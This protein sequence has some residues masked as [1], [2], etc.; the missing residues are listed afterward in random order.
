[1]HHSGGLLF[2]LAS[3]LPGAA[4]FQLLLQPDAV[5]L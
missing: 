4:V 5:K 1:M 3:Q 2:L